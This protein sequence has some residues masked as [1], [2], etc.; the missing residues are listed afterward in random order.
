MKQII[1]AIFIISALYL[2]TI[3]KKEEPKGFKH[4]M[5]DY[6]HE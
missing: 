4:T 2:F 1:I 3:S 5:S 6:L